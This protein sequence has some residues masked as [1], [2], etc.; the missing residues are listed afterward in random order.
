MLRL[1]YQLWSHFCFYWGTFRCELYYFGLVG[2]L[3]IKFGPIRTRKSLSRIS[4]FDF[5]LP[6][7]TSENKGKKCSRGKHCKVRLTG[8]AAAIC[9]YKSYKCF[10]QW[11]KHT[12]L[13]QGSA[14]NTLSLSWT[15][16]KLYI[17]SVRF[18]QWV[19]ELKNQF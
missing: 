9:M 2:Y 10:S 16:E 15:K 4:S 14:K 18:E 7:L 11:K 8:I 17:D 12:P 6:H 1:S 19:I 3:K 13:L 5:V